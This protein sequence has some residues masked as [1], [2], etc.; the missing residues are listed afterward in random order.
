M[1]AA[2]YMCSFASPR[3][4]R[5]IITGNTAVRGGGI[6]FDYRSSAEIA[7]TIIAGN[8]VDESGAGIDVRQESQGRLNHTTIADND[9]GDGSGIYIELGT[10]DLTN[11][12][13]A[14]QTVGVQVQSGGTITMDYTLWGGGN[15]SNG[16]DWAGVGDI[17]TGTVNFWGNPAFVQPSA[18]DYAPLSIGLWQAD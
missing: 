17:I 4:N 7:N 16:A 9:G 1:G 5:N 11:T 10:L 14:S 3:L 8:T 18:G 13:V 12:I 6:F 2:L 15:W